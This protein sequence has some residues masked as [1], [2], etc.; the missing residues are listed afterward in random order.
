MAA[1][2]DFSGLITSDRPA[3]AGEVIHAYGS[4]FGPVTEPPRTGEPASA[5][6]LSVLVDKIQCEL[7]M[8]ADN[9][10][11]QVLFAGLAPGMIGVYQIDLRMPEQLTGTAAIL[12]CSSDASETGAFLPTM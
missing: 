11:L 5:S 6:P 4:G 8:G 1:H 9:V 7:G 2:E 3:R 10:P 12:G